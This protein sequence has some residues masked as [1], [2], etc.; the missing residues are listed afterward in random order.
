MASSA[1][2][3]SGLSSRLQSLRSQI[4]SPPL[5]SWQSRQLKCVSPTRLDRP[6]RK[7]LRHVCWPQQNHYGPAIS[8]DMFPTRNTHSHPRSCANKRSMLAVRNSTRPCRESNGASSEEQLKAFGLASWG[9]AHQGG[10][11]AAPALV[12]RAE[13]PHLAIAASEE[14]QNSNQRVRRKQVRLLLRVAEERLAVCRGS[15]PP[16]LRHMPVAGNRYSCKI[17][18]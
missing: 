10:P 3:G 9:V 13:C 11:S 16:F 12:L 14:A 5:V 15:G 1:A 17:T 7:N 8:P 18:S 4:R 2:S 6:Q